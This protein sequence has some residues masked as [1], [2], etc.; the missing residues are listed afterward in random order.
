MEIKV[1][2]YAIL[3]AQDHVLLCEEKIKGGIFFKLP[4]G[5]LEIGESPAACLQRELQEELKWDC[6][7]IDNLCLTPPMYI[8]NKWNDKQQV[9]PL[10]YP[11][12]LAERL[13]FEIG[14]PE[15]ILA[16]HWVPF[17]KVIAQLSLESDRWAV[18]EVLDNLKFR[19]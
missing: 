2:V 13:N 14:A 9:I 16:L 11:V 10:Y 19:K 5:G 7:T 3:I 15:E 18:T 8:Q 4:G 17:T 1:R 12:N 6:P